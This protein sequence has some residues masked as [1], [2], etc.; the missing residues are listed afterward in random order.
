MKR[1]A[2]SCHT[3]R[4]MAS[5][6]HDIEIHIGQHR[7]EKGAM[8]G[9]DGE[10]VICR[11]EVDDGAK[12]GSAEYTPNHIHLRKVIKEWKSE[13]ICFV[14]FVHSHPAGFRRPSYGDLEYSARILD[15][16][17]GLELLWLPIV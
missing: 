13:G 6:R 8:L 11:I 14:G 7:A 10:G 5:I 15:H 3:M 1:I 2:E 9:S 4:M 16:F 17:E 12:T